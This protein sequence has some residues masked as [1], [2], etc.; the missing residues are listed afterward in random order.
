M[1]KVLS[2]VYVGIVAIVILCFVLLFSAIGA[3]GFYY[4]GNLIL[5]TIFSII[6]F[7][8][9]VSCDWIAY[10]DWPQE[11]QPWHMKYFWELRKKSERR[12]TRKRWQYIE[13]VRKTMTFPS[14]EKLRDQAADLTISDDQFD[15]IFTGYKIPQEES[16]YQNINDLLGH[17]MPTLAKVRPQYYLKVLEKLQFV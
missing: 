5:G 13:E 10:H 11:I 17:V 14:L 6:A 15:Q 4:N 12:K 9:Y 3:L 8:A 16:P 2:N 7:I 1:K